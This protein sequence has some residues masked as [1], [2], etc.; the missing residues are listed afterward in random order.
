IE[1]GFGSPSCLVTWFVHVLVV[2]EVRASPADIRGRYTGV[3]SKPFLN[4]N[5]VP[6]I[7]RQLSGIL[8]VDDYGTGS[9]IVTSAF[10]CRDGKIIQ[11]AFL[12][13]RVDIAELVVWEV[14]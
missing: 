1:D 11:A 6:L 8:I 10:G 4:L 5:H 2:D 3:G 7:V 14:I 13:D 9:L 12:L